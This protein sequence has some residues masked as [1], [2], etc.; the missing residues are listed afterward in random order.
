MTMNWKPTRIRSVLALAML[1]VFALL[2]GTLTGPSAAFAAS[3][4]TAATPQVTH[5]T[6]VGMYVAGFDAAV[7]KAHGYKIVTYANGEQQSV[8][9][10]PQ[11]K[12]PKSMILHPQPAKSNALPNQV[13]PAAAATDYNEV[14]GNCGKSWIR[15]TQTGTNKVSVASGFSNLPED[16]Y[17]WSWNVLLSDQNGTSHQTYSGAI[18]STSAS[19][20]WTNLNQYGFTYDYVYSGGATLIDGTI[21]LSG[22]PDVSIYL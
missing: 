3:R 6:Q 16:A 21:C 17:F 8:P 7:A 22:G 4:P 20:I 9:V 1:S 11:S 5:E 18:L 19:R 2:L 14:W 12:L 10:N 15:V 13:V